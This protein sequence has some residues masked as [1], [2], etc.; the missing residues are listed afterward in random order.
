MNHFTLS[1]LKKSA[2][3]DKLGINNSIPLSIIPNIEVLINQVLDPI[4]EYMNEPIYVNSGYRC[5]LLNKAVGGVAGSQ[6]VLGQA[7]DI[8][9]K[10]R[11]N[12]LIM[13]RYIE[14]N[15]VFDQMIIYKN[16]IHISYRT[17]GNRKQI[18]YKAK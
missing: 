9:T 3:A 2:T 1:E 17:T 7:A 11:E 12:N 16:F 8:T 15:I 13:E 5:P 14:E 10:S 18:I 4:R 6:H